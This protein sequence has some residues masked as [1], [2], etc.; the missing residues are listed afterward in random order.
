VEF[1]DISSMVWW[2][3]LQ[4]EYQSEGLLWE[5]LSL[6]DELVWRPR[7]CREIVLDFVEDGKAGSRVRRLAH[8]QAPGGGLPR[9]AP[10]RG[11]Q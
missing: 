6:S 4:S 11:L 10:A 5:I 2:E 8:V 1:V 9:K 3:G 7:C